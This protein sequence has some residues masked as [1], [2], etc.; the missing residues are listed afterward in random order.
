MTRVLAHIF[1][2]FYRVDTCVRCHCSSKKKKKKKKLNASSLSFSDASG[3]KQ[4][5]FTSPMYSRNV[6][7][8]FG[9]RKQDRSGDI[10]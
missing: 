5:F 2:A 4:R 3:R 10:V 1:S 7:V 9:P 8:V 6:S